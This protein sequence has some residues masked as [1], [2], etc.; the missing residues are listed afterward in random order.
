MVRRRPMVIGMDEKKS[1]TPTL[2]R[3]REREEPNAPAQ[4]LAR[5]REREGPIAKRWEGEGQPSAAKK[6]PETGGPAGPE[7]TRYGDWER[8][9]R[10]IDF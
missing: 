5:V 9:G 10:C 2:S 4:P 8:K 1:L 6:T 7:P 3:Q